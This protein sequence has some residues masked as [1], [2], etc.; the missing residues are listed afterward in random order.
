MGEKRRTFS[1]GDWLLLAFIL[2]V[3]GGTAAALVFGENAA[4][5]GLPGGGQEA[6]GEEWAEQFLPLLA[7]RLGAA[8]AAWVAGLTVCSAFLFGLLTF[9]AGMSAA[10]I[11]AIF[12]LKKGGAGILLFLSASLPQVIVYGFV[13]YVMSVWAKKRQKR[14]HIPGLLFLLALTAFGAFL[15]LPAGGH[16][17]YK[18]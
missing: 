1:Y 14:L 2:G 17:F 15:E 12:T 9:H 18:I 7:G 3:L 10:V 4:G 11:L 8:L 6:M 5:G 13:W 16:V